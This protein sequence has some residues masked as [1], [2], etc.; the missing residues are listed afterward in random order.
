MQVSLVVKRNDLD[1]YDYE[2]NT[3]LQTFYNPI[4]N[5]LSND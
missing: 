2:N 5:I 4:V 1:R 3:N